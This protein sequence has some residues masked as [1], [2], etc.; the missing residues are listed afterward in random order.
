[1]KF[2]PALAL[3]LL[4]FLLAPPLYA[5]VSYP[6]F[7]RGLNLTEAQKRRAEEA[8]QRYIQDWNLQRQEALK[9]RFELRELEKDPVR[10]RERIFRAQ[11]ELI[12][13][14]RSQERSYNQYRSELSQVLN[15]RQ[16]EQYDRFA[17]TEKRKRML[18]QPRP[19]LPES[20]IYDYRG[21]GIKSYGSPRSREYN[22][23]RE[24]PM[25]GYER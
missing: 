23:S 2:Y 11:R 18:G 6:E 14:E 4:S 3:L 22:P 20:R 13:M 10:N 16:R 24:R 8:K 12:E 15:E 21:R 5:Q 17:D 7:E 19:Q 25:K 9:K 1:M